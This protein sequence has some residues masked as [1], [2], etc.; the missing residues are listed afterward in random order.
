MKRGT[1]VFGLLLLLMLLASCKQGT[2]YAA[3]GDQIAAKNSVVT[4]SGIALN[5]ATAT[6]NVNIL[7]QFVATGGTPPYTFT[8]TASGS[9]SPSITNTGLYR[10][11]FT[12]PGIDTVKVTDSTPVT[13]KVATATVNVSA[14]ATNVDYTIQS[15]N[16]P[17]AGNGGQPIPPGFNFIVKNNGAAN[18]TQP[19]SW[20]VYISDSPTFNTSGMQVLCGNVFGGLP[21]LGTATFQIT[22]TWPVVSGPGPPK[23]LFFQIAA[24]DDLNPN[25]NVY[26]GLST[27]VT[28]SPPN[29]DYAVSAVTNMG[30]ATAPVLGPMTGKFHLNNGGPDNGTQ[31]VS[32]AA[33]A[34]PRGAVDSSAV[35][36]ATGST[37]PLPASGSTD[38]PFSGQWPMRYGNY[39]LVVSVSVPVEMD[40]NLS[41]LVAA[42]GSTAAVGF[43]PETEPNDTVAT[44]QNLGVTLQPGM[45]VLVT[46]SVAGLPAD[47]HDVF[48]FNT[49]TA[50]SVSLYMSWPGS[51]NVTLSFYKNLPVVTQL[52]PTAS[53]VT[54]SSLILTWNV[55][56][57]GTPRWIDVNTPGGWPVGNIPYTLI[58]T[59]N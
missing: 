11:G 21:S 35:L 26:G 36:I 32:W 9:G 42:S 8:L 20:W 18:G 29:V 10:S 33:Y 49:G 57:A 51:Q 53:T 39:Q 30:A 2:F 54:G 44:A 23:Y 14:T 22:G 55:D 25:N 43:I 47:N 46:R 16:P 15:V 1:R 34:S 3:L 27:P 59:A 41:N 31:Y 19:L 58:I 40:T 28:L 17:V 52:L 6:V 37:P 48:A 13:P 12:T 56:S 4:S 5:P 50:T 38:I 24:A 45:S 7:L